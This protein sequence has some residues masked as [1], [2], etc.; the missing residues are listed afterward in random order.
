MPLKS[1]WSIPIPDAA[2][3]TVIFK[4][5]T[6][7]LSKTRR[8]FSDAARP[9]THYLTTHD[10]RLWCQRFAAG[11]R[12]SGLR[13][14]DRVLLFSANNLLFPVA[15]MGV[16]MAGCI[17][18]GANPTYTPRELAYQLKDS[19]A[20]YLLCADGSIDTG[21][22]AAD[23]IGMGRDKVFV[24]NDAVYDGKVEGLK[25]CRHWGE[26]IASEEEGSRFVW[27]P[28]GSPAE[29]DRTLALNYSSGTT[30]VP[31]GVEI[32]HKNYVAN[33]LQFNHS[34]TLDPDYEARRKDAR[35]LCFLPFY[36]AMAQNIFIASALMREIPVYIMARFDFV[37][38]LEYIQKFRTSDLI[39]VPPIAI[40]LT[41]H[42]AVKQYDLSS[43][44]SL[45]SG[46]APLGLEVSEELESMF[47]NRMNV[48]Q[49]WG[50]TE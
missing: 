30:G 23:S 14:G 13:P 48:R 38:M 12:K 33:L 5:P 49:G 34:T 42:P 39:M 41:K 20:S 2:L 8:S 6:H 15:F 28:L 50:M 1:R 9:D 27:D 26:L 21:L 17:F 31:K 25:G 32:S 46:A 40:A 47:S 45:G 16:V 29:A 7:P 19:G 37:Q 22:A 24:Y 4:S 44:Q 43:I 3:P 10:Y 36:H 35:F 18:T 11:L